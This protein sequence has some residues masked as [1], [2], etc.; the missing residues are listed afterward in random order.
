MTKENLLTEFEEINVEK[1][2]KIRVAT[3]GEWIKE[4]AEQVTKQLEKERP[5]KVLSNYRSTND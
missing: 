4:L 3:E 1:L 2:G 5:Y